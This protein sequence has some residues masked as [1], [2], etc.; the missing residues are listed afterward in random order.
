MYIYVCTYTVPTLYLMR[1]TLYLMRSSLYQ[2]DLKCRGVVNFAIMELEASHEMVS[3]SSS[4]VRKVWKL[5][6]YGRL[7]TVEPVIFLYMFGMFLSSTL[8][9][10]YYMNRYS[11]DILR[12]TSYPY[13]GETR[14]V[15]KED[16]TNY[17]G[18]PT[19][20]GKI[21]LGNATLLFVF[22]SLASQIP[23]I[24][25]TM[26][27]GPLSDRYGR[28]PVI[29]LVAF[30]AVLHGYMNLSIVYFKL[31]MQYFILSGAIEGVTGGLSSITMACYSY[32]SDISS[33]KWRTMRIGLVQSMLYVA[34]I[35]SRGLG[36]LWFQKLNCDIT[37]PL[38]LFMACNAAIIVYVTLFLSE[39]LTAKER[40][41]KN[42]DKPK[43][44]MLLA[45]GISIF[46]C[47]TKE[48]PVWRMWLALV[49]IVF[50]TMIMTAET[51]TGIFYFGA[52][53]WKP[54]LI[55]INQALAMGSHMVCA[56][57]VL[58]ILV[59]LKLP[60]PLISL[61]GAVANCSMNFFIGLSRYPYELFIGECICVI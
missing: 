14:C 17:T 54:V 56:M 22:R 51:A 2:S 6:R 8:S 49:P 39:S 32:V 36:L 10:Q 7:L 41:K 46:L 53:D 20:Y 44:V 19:A 61:I 45:R 27:L 28:C 43:G 40:R 48:Y 13:L 18:D 4:V 29:L 47:R 50:M 24:V 52:V 12:N 23:A 38:V 9:Q 26:L 31:D 60:D 1:S 57:V 33:L 42:V 15:Y 37:Y 35:M 16:V 34:G 5:C 30:G 21:V 11:L 25:V 3:P 59:A 58:P 55:G